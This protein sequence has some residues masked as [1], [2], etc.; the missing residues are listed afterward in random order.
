MREE[1]LERGED[2]ALFPIL[3]S[4]P[5]IFAD[6]VWIW[7]GFMVLTCA[8]QTG[9]S[10]LQP[11]PISEVLAYCQYAGISDPDDREH[12]MHH[13]QKLDQYTLANFRANSAPTPPKGGK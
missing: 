8:R 1:I 5:E 6:L 10:S 12:F 2:P 9:Y 4:K 11:I 7:E 3:N 13:V